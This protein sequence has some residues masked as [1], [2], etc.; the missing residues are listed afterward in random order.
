M[1]SIKKGCSL[2]SRIS[3][4]DRTS[5]QY[6]SLYITSQFCRQ[7]THAIRY[8]LVRLNCSIFKNQLQLKIQLN[9]GLLFYYLFQDLE[10]ELQEVKSYYSPSIKEKGVYYHIAI[11]DYLQEWNAEKKIVQVRKNPLMQKQIQI[12]RLKILQSIKKDLLKKVLI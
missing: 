4:F 2:E 1:V 8:I 7:L 10:I 6:Y 5:T 9:Y 12:L 11:I 3:K